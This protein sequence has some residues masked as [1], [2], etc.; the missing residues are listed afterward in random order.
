LTNCS[1]LDNPHSPSVHP[2]GPTPEGRLVF[3]KGGGHLAFRRRVDESFHG[4]S[5]KVD[6]VE[7]DLERKPSSLDIGL[8]RPASPGLVPLD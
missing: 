8:A 7:H 3:G 5:E 2:R 1:L 4:G 6:W